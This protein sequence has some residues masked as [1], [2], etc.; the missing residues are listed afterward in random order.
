MAMPQRLIGLDMK[1]SQPKMRPINPI[2]CFF[3]NQLSV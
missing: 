2:K 1:L 3:G